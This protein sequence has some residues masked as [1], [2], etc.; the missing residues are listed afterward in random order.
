MKELSYQEQIL[1]HTLSLEAVS[2][3]FRIDRLI[4]ERESLFAQEKLFFNTDYREPIFENSKEI[5][6]LLTKYNIKK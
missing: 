1:A 5:H 3:C 2:D 6:E 4:K